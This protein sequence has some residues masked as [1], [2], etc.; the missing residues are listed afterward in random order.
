MPVALALHVPRHAYSVRER[1]RAGDIWRAFQEAAVLGSSAVGWPP[2]RYR[3]EDCA[4]VVRRM[5][6]VHH[7]ECTYGEP[8]QA[9]TWVQDFRR[10]L[11]TTREI[12]LTGTGGRALAEASQEWVHVRYT[13]RADGTLGLRP[14]RAQPELLAAFP[15]EDHGPSPILPD[16]DGVQGAPVHHFELALRLTEMDPLGHLNHPAY[17]DLVDEHTSALLHAAGL[18]PVALQPI[19]E[20]VRFRAGIEAPGAARIQTWLAGTTPDA[21]V[22]GHRIL[23]PDGELAAEATTVRTLADAGPRALQTLLLQTAQE[24]P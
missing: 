4:F 13:R 5:V 18:D 11:L 7:A 1:A 8:V 19:A 16:Y 17:V 24:T 6:V 21:V 10:G 2:P 9:R 12:R 23:R 14:A 3:E 22:L 20:E 15:E